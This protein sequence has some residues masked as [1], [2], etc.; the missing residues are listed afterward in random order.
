MKTAMTRGSIR[1]SLRA[2]ALAVLFAAGTGVSAF[3]ETELEGGGA[4][5]KDRVFKETAGQLVPAES[6][7]FG[8]QTFDRGWEFRRADSRI[9]L[10][11]VGIGNNDNGITSLFRETNGWRRVDIPH[12]WKVE[13]PVSRHGRAGFRAAERECVRKS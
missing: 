1:G 6:F 8:E 5:D 4:L 7:A 12:D 9:W 2:G 11:K 13:M 3:A 10:A